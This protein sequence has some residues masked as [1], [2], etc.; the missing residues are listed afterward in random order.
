MPEGAFYPCF[1]AGLY[2]SVHCVR[3][4]FTLCIGG[5]GFYVCQYLYSFIDGLYAPYVELPFFDRLKHFVAEHEM[6][7]VLIRDHNTL[8]ACESEYFT[9]AEESLYLLVDPAYR[10]DIAKL[11]NRSGHGNVLFKRYA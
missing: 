4:I 6:L 3:L 10:L 8:L 2:L 11:I 7:F 5:T 1:K 9:V